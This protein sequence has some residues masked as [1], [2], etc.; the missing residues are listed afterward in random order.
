M[1]ACH[2]GGHGIETHTHRTIGKYFSW[3]RIRDL[4]SRGRRF[5]SCLPDQVSVVIVDWGV[6][7]PYIRGY[8]DAHVPEVQG[9][10]SG[11][12]KWF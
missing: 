9:N 4:G 8:Y 10:M 12:R 2:V 6:A 7:K 5:E 3:F 11:L 1:P